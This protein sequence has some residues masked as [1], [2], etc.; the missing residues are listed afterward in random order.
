M[1]SARR[2][3]VLRADGESGFECTGSNKTGG[4][5]IDGGTLATSGLVRHPHADRPD[6]PPGRHD[7]TLRIGP[8]F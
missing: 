6:R 8:V 7:V 1:F 2:C 4:L 5:W 3:A